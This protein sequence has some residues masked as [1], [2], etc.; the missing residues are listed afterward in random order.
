M[1]ASLRL[2]RRV[3]SPGRIG[4]GTG[5]QDGANRVHGVLDARFAVDGKPSFQRDL[6]VVTGPAAAYRDRIVVG[7]AR[8]GR[9]KFIPGHVV[10]ADCGHNEAVAIG[11]F[12]GQLAEPGTPPSSPLFLPRPPSFLPILYPLLTSTSFRTLFLYPAVLP[13]ASLAR[14][15]S[16][17]LC[18][19][20]L[21]SQACL[22][23]P[24]PAVAPPSAARARAVASA[25]PCA[26]SAAPRAG[27]AALFARRFS[28]RPLL[29]GRVV[30]LP[31]S[32]LCYVRPGALSRRSL[33]AL[34]RARALDWSFTDSTAAHTFLI[35][36]QHRLYSRPPCQ[37]GTQG[38]PGRNRDVPRSPGPH[39]P[40]R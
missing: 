18:L 19:P 11:Q 22:G 2:R 21:V 3:G 8:Q 26:A 33:S 25:G 7:R 30:S 24:A 17:P 5:S 12:D 36:A 27:L 28:S 35:L 39:Q 32:A 31:R 1:T 14:L 10:V 34:P 15:Y 20:S 29:A 4:A 37:R 16:S 40:F 38:A 23:S 9:F 6:A 13:A